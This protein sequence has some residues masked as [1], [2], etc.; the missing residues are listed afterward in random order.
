[1]VQYSIVQHTMV[2]HST[3][4]YG[5]IHYGTGQFLYDMYAT[6]EYSNQWYDTVQYG[7]V[8]CDAADAARY[9]TLWAVQNSTVRYHTVPNSQL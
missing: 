1:M 2:R 8:R 9:G 7:M 6:V 3:V 4:W 5:T